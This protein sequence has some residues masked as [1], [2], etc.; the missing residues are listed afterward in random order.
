MLLEVTSASI[1]TLL[2]AADPAKSP[3]TSRSIS[4]MTT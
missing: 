1:M 4:V 3:I 2:T